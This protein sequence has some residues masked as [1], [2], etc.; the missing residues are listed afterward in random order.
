MNADIKVKYIIREI[1]SDLENVHSKKTPQPFTG[2]NKLDDRLQGNNPGSVIFIGAR[3][4]M[5][6]TSFVLNIALNLSVNYQLPVF[7]IASD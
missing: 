7:I 6:K 2:Y 4:G 3:P 1:V 5:G